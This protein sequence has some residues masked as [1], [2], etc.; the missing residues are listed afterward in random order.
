MDTQVVGAALF[1]V[2]GEAAFAE[3]KGAGFHIDHARVNFHRVYVQLFNFGLFYIIDLDMVF[4]PQIIIG[5]VN[6]Q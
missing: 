5:S 1:D 4:A 2:Q 6:V 3:P